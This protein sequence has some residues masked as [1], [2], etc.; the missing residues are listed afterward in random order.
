MQVATLACE[1]LLTLALMRNANTAATS[2]TA[3]KPIYS[4]SA[5]QTNGNTNPPSIDPNAE[6][7]I[8]PK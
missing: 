8:E 6:P 4:M 1:A 2:R 7:I 3:P 5:G